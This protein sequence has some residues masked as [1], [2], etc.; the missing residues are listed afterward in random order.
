MKKKV[1]QSQAVG[2]TSLHDY[3]REFAR[4]GGKARS[5]KKA[6]ASRRNGVLGGR[7]RRS[8]PPDGQGAD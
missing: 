5:A 2:I 6:E 4:L 3:A 8:L 1:A 7:P